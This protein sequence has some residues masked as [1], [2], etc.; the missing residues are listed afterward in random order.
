MVSIVIRRESAVRNKTTH[1]EQTSHC[2]RETGFSPYLFLLIVGIAFVGLTVAAWMIWRARTGSI[3]RQRVGPDDPNSLRLL[4]VRPDCGEQVYD[5]TG[6]PL[7]KRHVGNTHG[8]WW[9][10]DELKR[11]FAF[12]CRIDGKNQ[13]FP[14]LVSLQLNSM[15]G[16]RDIAWLEVGDTNDSWVTFRCFTKLPRAMLSGGFKLGPIRLP[17]RKEPVRTVDAH[18]TYHAGSRGPARATFA[19]P[20][21]LGQQ[22]RSQENPDILMRVKRNA[23]TQLVFVFSGPPPMEH[24]APVIAYTE[25]GQRHRLDRGSGRT[26]SSQG[27]SWEYR[28]RD[29]ALESITHITLDETPTKQMYRGI[30]VS[31][32]GLPIRTYP[33]Y[34]D[35]VAARLDLKVNLSTATEEAVRE[36]SNRRNPL[37]SPSDAIGILDIAQGNW[38]NRAVETLQNAEPSDLT[39]DERK[40]L[41]DILASWVDSDREI[42]ACHLG[43]WA[44]WPDY[45]NRALAILRTGNTANR[46]LG[47]LA[48]ALCKYPNPSS[49]L[50]TGLTDLL[51]SKSIVDQHPR[52]LIGYI[53]RNSGDETENL[54]RLAECDK[55]W[56]WCWI[57][58]PRG[59]FRDLL[60]KVSATPI[61][62]SRMVAVG[63]DDWI[64]DPDSLKPQAYDILTEAITPE[65]VQKNLSDFDRMFRL[66]AKHTPVDKGTE[67][68]IRYLERQLEE[69]DKWQTEG[70]ASSNYYGIIKA[71]RQLNNWYT[72]NLGGL[73][74]N[75]DREVAN[76]RYDWQEIAASALHWARTGEDQSRLPP[77]WR[78]SQRDLRVVWYNL[79]EPER[80]VIGLFP[81]GQDANL[82]KPQAA[83]EGKEDFLQYTIVL[84]ED[85]AKGTESYDFYVRAGVGQGH[86]VNRVFTFTLAD[87]PKLFDPGPT[88]M[89]G[90]SADGTWR[91][92]PLW[93]GR[94]EIRIERAAAEMS[95]LDGTQLFVAWKAQYLTDKP[96]VP[97]LER[98]F[99][100]DDPNVVPKDGDPLLLH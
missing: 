27:F 99:S 61:M 52:Q 43:I 5:A 73:G 21:H 64:G 14:P 65:F 98:V 70:W 90:R 91:E 2:K 31:Y 78:M 81:A 89:S 29:L 100:R 24:E 67:V 20:F 55:P 92:T 7:G 97:P 93:Q 11:E 72:L 54:R 53:C 69:W 60:R 68:L 48:Q 79:D 6:Q 23:A 15:P 38:L 32:P 41:A 57:I 87:L 66:F 36:F 76:F 45:A 9:G 18:I 46:R 94:W 39:A 25:G 40:K 56:I 3:P 85:I 26:S 75:L 12:A 4:Y 8:D 33:A 19:G 50:L 17:H 34:L 10:P 13:L 16:R 77:N 30:K 63:M 83:M 51:V 82:P 22:A 1:V 44:G 59:S 62:K 28:C 49:E 74:R 47:Q 80:S 58:H 37:D 86:C 95:V 71:V 35:E 96:V 42:S 84:D 88:N